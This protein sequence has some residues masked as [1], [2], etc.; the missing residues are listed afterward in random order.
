MEPCLPASKQDEILSPNVQS[1]QLIM[2]QSSVPLILQI[3]L[4]RK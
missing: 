1:L 3:S 4:I 2:L